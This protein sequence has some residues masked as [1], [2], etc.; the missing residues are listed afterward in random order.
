LPFRDWL[1]VAN[2]NMGEFNIS[3]A[4]ASSQVW[5]ITNPLNPVNMQGNFSNGTFKFINNC[6]RLREYVCFTGNEFLR[7]G[8]VGKISNQDLHNSLPEDY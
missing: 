7:P 4:S 6:N 2:G 5:D 8:L 1:T 3:N